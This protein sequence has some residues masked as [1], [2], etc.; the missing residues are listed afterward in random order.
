VILSPTMALTTVTPHRRFNIGDRYGV[1][2]TLVLPSSYVN[3]GEDYTVLAE[4]LGLTSG[5]FDHFEVSPT[6]LFYFETDYADELLLIRDIADG[7]EVVDQTDLDA[8]EAR[9]FVIG[10]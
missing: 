9:V 3:G 10:H 5:H 7:T 1:V 6:G 2:A 8:N 4:K